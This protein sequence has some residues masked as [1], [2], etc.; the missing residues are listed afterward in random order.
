MMTKTCNKCG[1]TLP[2]TEF[3]TCP[4][5]ARNQDNTCKNCRRV[6][7]GRIRTP[8]ILH[9][10]VCNKD[11][12]YYDFTIARK[13]HTGRMWCCTKCWKSN[14]GMSENN[15]RK[16]YDP[17]FR[18][19]IYKQKRE[20]RLRNFVHCMWKAAKNRALHRG[21]EFTI[22]EADIVIPE[23]CPLLGV[24]FQFGTKGNYHYSPSLDRID[25]TKGYIK[26]NVWV[27]SMKANTMKNSATPK[28]LESFCKGILRYS[29]T[30]LE[31]EKAELGDKEPLG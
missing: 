22:D 12:P 14:P 19:L 7:K 31:N 30:C 24:P 1:Q 2:I 3:Y 6:Q 5:M 8:D 21:I 11:L 27:I 25:N 29:P 4:S 16:T 13:S 9:C 28:E 15:F 10:P 17:E 26:G 18:Q 23:K 20:S